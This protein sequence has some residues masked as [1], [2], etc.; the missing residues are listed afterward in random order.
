MRRIYLF[1]ICSNTIL[2]KLIRKTTKAEFTHASISLHDEIF[3]CYSFGRKYSKLVLPAGFKEEPFDSG[4]LKD[5]KNIKCGLFYIDVTDEQHDRAS[6]YI[7]SLQKSNK[8]LGFN[9]FGL[10]MCKFGKPVKRKHKM[11]CSE[12]VANTLNHCGVANFRNTSLVKPADLIDIPNC[13]CIYRGFV[14]DVINAI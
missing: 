9:F 14:R 4:F 7:K 10:L 1:L 12:F 8:R 6:R 13:H 11:F 3:P 5:N 2:S